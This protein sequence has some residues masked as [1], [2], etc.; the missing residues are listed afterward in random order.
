MTGG[1][2]EHMRAWDPE[3]DEIIITLLNELGPKWSRIVQQLPGRSVSSVRNRWQRI[4]KGRK[5]R[6]AGQESKNRCQ[7][8]GQPKRGH[9]CTAKL[10]NRGGGVVVAISSRTYEVPASGDESD[11]PMLSRENSEASLLRAA[12]SASRAASASASDGAGS[13]LR[14][15]ERAGAPGAADAD[16]T[17]RMEEAAVPMLGRM[18]SAGR[19]CSELGFEALAAA[20]IHMS[21]REQRAGGAAEARGNAHVPGLSREL[22]SDAAPIIVPLARQMSDAPPLPPLLHTQPSLLVAGSSSL[23]SPACSSGSSQPPRLS[24]A[25]PSPLVPSPSPLCTLSE[26]AGTQRYAGVGQHFS[27][28]SASTDPALP[29]PSPSPNLGE[30]PTKPEPGSEIC[31]ASPHGGPGPQPAADAPCDADGKEAVAMEVSDEIDRRKAQAER[32][33]ELSLPTPGPDLE[34]CASSSASTC[35]SI[36]E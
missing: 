9:V 34:A 3:E 33:R 29:A 1:V 23:L 14:E 20:A 24:A 30:G 10:K 17:H 25:P 27:F 32:P 12:A 26:R 8:C 22:S 35:T 16:S 21:A 15:A 13:P 6:E 11:T 5:L 28:A 7:R 36:S 4:E 31:G 18:R 19:I 2:H